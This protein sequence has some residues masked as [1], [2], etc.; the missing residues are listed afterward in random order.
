MSKPRNPKIAAILSF[1]APGLGQLYNREWLKGGIILTLVLGAVA[2]YIWTAVNA[3]LMGATPEAV[4]TLLQG[5]GW[6]FIVLTVVQIG[7]AVEAY[8]TGQASAPKPGPRP[9]R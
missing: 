5:T 6:V 8:L 2:Y 4:E 1:V 3:V 9:R 7:A